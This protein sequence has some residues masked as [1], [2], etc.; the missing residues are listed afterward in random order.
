VATNA[1]G[2]VRSG[3]RSNF[4]GRAVTNKI[5]LAIPNRDFRAMRPQLE[6]VD[7]PARFCLHEAG[8]KVEFAYFPN[9]GMVSLVVVTK[10][11][12]TVEVG[13]VGN[14][15]M[16]GLPGAVYLNR[17]PLR[18][19][20]QIAGEGFRIS[21]RALQ[22]TLQSF[23]QLNSQL[24]RYAVLHGMQVSQTAACNRLHDMRP[25]LARW[26][27]MAQD[28]VDCGLLQVTHD[29]LAT[30]LG[31]D[32]PSVSLAAGFLQKQQA[33]SYLRGA[34]QILNRKRLESIACEC[35]AVMSQFNGSLGIK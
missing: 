29:F 9:S 7:L 13:V 28:R 18:E 6:F 30:M 12:R 14:E 23:P 5:L 27:L 10:D 32:R 22:E 15:G 35:Y 31:T 19:I 4:Q 17:S 26:L 16:A 3:E 11:G 21:V 24:T 2:V 8:D 20:I 1:L 33:I 25:R 34:V